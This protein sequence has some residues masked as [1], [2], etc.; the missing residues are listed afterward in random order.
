MQKEGSTGETS[1]P[2]FSPKGDDLYLICTKWPGEKLALKSPKP[3]AESKITMLGWP[4]RVEWKMQN[5]QLQ[6][7]VPQLTIDKLPCRYAWV[8]KIAGISP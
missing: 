4:G 2:C 5:N 3:T 1:W 6:I 7:Q 8:L